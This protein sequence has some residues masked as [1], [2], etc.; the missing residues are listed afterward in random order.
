[1]TSSEYQL[2]KTGTA[3][4]RMRLYPTVKWIS[5]L[6][7][8]SVRT[9]F[10]GLRVVA[11]V[12]RVYGLISTVEVSNMVTPVMSRTISCMR[13]ESDLNTISVF[14]SS[15]GGKVMWS[16]QS[17]YCASSRTVGACLWT[18]LGSGGEAVI[19]CVMVIRGMPGGKYSAFLLLH[20]YI[21][22]VKRYYVT[23]LMDEY[24]VV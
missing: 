21:S 22:L 9:C 4:W 7:F 15:N 3:A 5:H 18:L 17:S 8:S 16:H 14:D 12:N 6:P 24:C 1:M 13:H 10:S 2:L 23:E 19:G 11:F 20:S